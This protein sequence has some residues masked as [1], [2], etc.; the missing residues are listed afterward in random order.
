MRLIFLLLLTIVPSQC[1]YFILKPGIE[2]CFQYDLIFKSVYVGEYN[3]LEQIPNLSSE[4]QGVNVKIFEPQ[5]NDYYSKIVRG[6]DR[7]IFNS[8][9]SGMHKICFEGTK[10]LFELIDEVKFYVKMHDELKYKEIVDSAIKMNDLDKGYEDLRRMKDTLDSIFGQF[11]ES[12]KNIN[13]FEILQAKYYSRAVLLAIMTIILVIAAGV[14]EIY[15]FKRSVIRDDH[16]R[17]R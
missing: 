2:R 8:K 11:Q 16:R 15:L 12:E 4:L 14:C 7:H 1:L 5:S 10:A 6:K 17:F 3:I 13:N 9:K